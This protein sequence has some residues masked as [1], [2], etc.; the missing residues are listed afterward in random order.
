MKQ[1]NS[2]SVLAAAVLGTI[3]CPLG[4]YAAQ[5]EMGRIDTHD[6]MVTATRT[7]E[8]V[9]NIPNTVAVITHD[10]IIKSGATDVYSALRFADNIY[11]KDGGTGTDKKLS[12]RGMNTNQA[13]ILV[14]GRR[15]AGEDTPQEQ[16]G[17]VLSRINMASIDRIEII[18]GAASSQ[19]GSDALAGV[20]NI[21]TKSSEGQPSV[22]VGADT[23][24]NSMNNYYHI[25]LG[26]QGN[27]SGTVDVNFSKDRNVLTPNGK[28]GALYGPTQNYN[29]SGTWDFDT[30]RSLTFDASYYKSNQ[31]ADWTKEMNGMLYGMLFN[32]Q[33]PM[34]N[35]MATA[36]LQD[37][38]Q[39]DYTHA[40]IDTTQKDFA[41]TYQGKTKNHDFS[42]R[43]YRTELNKYRLLPYEYIFSSIGAVS[44]GPR[45][46]VGEH[47]TYRIWGIDGH[48]NIRLNEDHVL[49][50]GG[51]YTKNTLDGDNIVISG[52]TQSKDTTTYAAYVQDE[53]WL[54]DK[55]LLIPAVRYD[56]HSDFGDKTTPK[57]GATYFVDDHNRLKANWGEGFKAPTVSEL[58]MDYTHA[59][60]TIW[61]NSSLQPETSKNWDL[62]YEYDNQ[63]TSAKLTYF[64][65]DV[66]N[67]IS[68]QTIGSTQYNS[69]QQYYNIPGETQTHGIELTVRRQFNPFWNIRV[70]SDWTSGNNNTVSAGVSSYNPHDVDGIA[71]NVTT[72]E[73]NYDD[74]KA[75]GFG[76]TL[77]NQWYT[78]YY[79]STYH[80][81]YSY[82]TTNFVINKKLGPNRRVFVGV[83]NLF[84]KKIGDIGLDGRLWRVGA[85]VRI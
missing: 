21:I 3:I 24:K 66:N 15:L 34:P 45:A 31:I 1:P 29:F 77:W 63:G 39:Y 78:N 70:N 64:H 38:K 36:V 84:D 6:V 17:M 59:G 71:D 8:E 19:Y 30:N 67:M 13:L 61:G 56:H 72:V 40:K 14:N 16:N 53:W 7:E 2:Y 5:P 27:F 11:I 79:D 32:P 26:K 48:D 80:Q 28:L 49:T 35:G 23:S 50:I 47:N 75:D 12:I 41:L 43:A 42:L 51:E 82:N 73:L 81:D 58:Y 60:N 33:R 22:T 46:K 25:D 57:M 54:N 44:G 65:N 85:E 10:D 83:D 74:Q 52:T 62:S 68:T 20:V 69:I 4:I 9:Q 76:V 55:L 37:V 18:R